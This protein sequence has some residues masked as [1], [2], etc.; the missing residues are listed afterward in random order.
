MEFET[1]V[2]GEHIFGFGERAYNFKLREG[3]FTIYPKDQEK[4][5]EE[6]K[7]NG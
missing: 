3:I 6:G 2:P 1:I 5:M 7:G 4:V